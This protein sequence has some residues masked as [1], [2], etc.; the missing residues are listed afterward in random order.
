VIAFAGLIERIIVEVKSYQSAPEHFQRL[1]L[2]L[3]FLSQVCIQIHQLEP[4]SSGE[5]AHLQRIRAISIKCLGPLRA[6]EEKMRKFDS[7][8]SA[9]NWKGGSGDIK[10]SAQRKLESFRKRLHWSMIEKREVDEL[11]AIL[12]SE[13]LAINTLLGTQQWSVSLSRCNR[14]CTLQETC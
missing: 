9:D 10:S 6:F 8:L 7:V 13:I 5:M 3:S 12:A 11:R 14:Y 1:A 2:E 4:T